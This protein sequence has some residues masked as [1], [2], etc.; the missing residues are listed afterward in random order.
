MVEGKEEMKS[1]TV[2]TV[3]EVRGGYVDNWKVSKA[4]REILN[5]KW[6]WP[7]KEFKD[8]R[9]MITCK[10]P[11]E[12]GE[13][14]KS[15][16]L[17]FP[18]F[19]MKCEPWSADIWRVGPADGKTRWLD[20]RRLL[21]FCWNRDS[22]GR[23]LKSVC[24]L[25]SVD[26]RGGCYVDDIRVLVRVRSRRTLPCIIWTNIGSRKYKVL[27][28]ME[29]GQ[30]PLPWNGGEVGMIA[31]DMEEENSGLHPLTRKIEKDKE[32]AQP[33][34]RKQESS[35]ERKQPHGGKH[36]DDARS[37]EKQKE[38]G[39]KQP[40]DRPAKA[41]TGEESHHGNTART[42]SASKQDR[43]KALGPPGSCTTHSAEKPLHASPSS[44][45][46]RR[47][48][49]QHLD[50]MTQEESM[51]SDGT[52][53]TL[54]GFK[55]K[56]LHGLE[57]RTLGEV[58]AL[59][60]HIEPI[61]T[62]GTNCQESGCDPSIERA[63]KMV[64]SI[65]ITQKDGNILE[66]LM[67]GMDLASG[68]HLQPNDFN[69]PS[70]NLNSGKALESGRMAPTK[71]L[72]PQTNEQAINAQPHDSINFYGA[73]QG[74]EPPQTKQDTSCM[75]LPCNSQ[76][77]TPHAQHIM[78]LIN[79]GIID[80]NNTFPKY[81]NGGWNLFSNTTWNNTQN[82]PGKDP[83]QTKK[84]SA[85]KSTPKEPVPTTMGKGKSVVAATRPRGR[86][87]KTKSLPELEE[88]KT[89]TSDTRLMERIDPQAIEP[90]VVVPG[91]KANEAVEFYKEVFAAEEVKRQ[92][93]PRALNAVQELPHLIL[94]AQLKIG[95]SSFLVCDQSDPTS[96]TTLCRKTEMG[97]G[98]VVFRLETDNVAGALERA[99]KAGAKKE[100]EIAE[101]ACVCAGVQAATVI[102]PFGVAWILTSASATVSATAKCC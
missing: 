44:S 92:T 9:M 13:M 23:V 99:V 66:D 73:Q 94:C 19:S 91:G 48:E 72:G 83:P 57:S 58:E 80:L 75:T 88:E 51:A 61:I 46:P 4:L 29:R 49:E 35:K 21:T 40:A 42:G 41:L 82:L 39:K 69:I 100:G 17:H 7:V 24:D 93:H 47:S 22:A 78:D 3:T 8:G 87:K 81:M 28:G 34:R 74:T 89:T 64:E 10:S 79:H 63:G 50:I 18:E 26:R 68:S 55:A 97:S 20:V 1:Y 59:N 52:K 36:G 85:T 31:A 2:A 16:E 67:N 33:A 11:A 102:D 96:S 98:T 65:Y 70:L 54:H 14:E 38:K 45:V 90:Q 53:G 15:G 27:V 84:D 30:D 37:Q 25:L 62:D 43:S 12:A 76:N 77:M 71:L 60:S 101:E 56:S 86:P 5:G 95:S 32:K 6:D